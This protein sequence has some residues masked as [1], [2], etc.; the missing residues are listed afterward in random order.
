MAQRGF[1]V[2]WGD[3]AGLTKHMAEDDA[4]MGSVMKALGLVKT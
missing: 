4:K 2:V 1:G 3:P